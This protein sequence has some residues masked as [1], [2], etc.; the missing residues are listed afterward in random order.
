MYKAISFQHFTGKFLGAV[1]MFAQWLNENPN[2]E[3]FKTWDGDST[4]FVIYKEN[5]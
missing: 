2:V 5:V 1:Q 3:I 4:I